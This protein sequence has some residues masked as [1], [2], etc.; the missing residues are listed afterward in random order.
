M[1]TTD[2]FYTMQW[3]DAETVLNSSINRLVLYGVSGTGKTYAALFNRKAEQSIHRII[4]TEDM[5][6]GQIEGMWYPTEN[7]FEFHEGEAV[8]AWRNGGRLVID[9]VSRASTDVM[10]LLLLFTDT[11]TSSN[12]KNPQTGEVVTPHKNFSVV[13]TMNG[14]PEDLDPALRDRFSCRIRIDTPHPTAIAM[15]PEK[16]QQPAFKMCNRPS[17]ERLSIRAF[18]DLAVLEQ[19]TDLETAL[20]I[21]CPQQAYAIKS[22]IEVSELESAK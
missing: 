22:A 19:E 8:Q 12:W 21:I 5:N 17:D 4:C 13:M 6:A 18:L 16:Y 2:P 15:L 10:S 7:G 9:E 14:E 20:R 1:E 3:Q 11:N